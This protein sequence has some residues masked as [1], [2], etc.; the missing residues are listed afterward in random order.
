[1]G[2]KSGLKERKDNPEYYQLYLAILTNIIFF[3]SLCSF[4]ISETF[5]QDRVRPCNWWATLKVLKF[6]LLWI[7]S[8]LNLSQDVFVVAVWFFS[9]YF[10]LVPSSSFDL[11]TMSWP[12]QEEVKQKMCLAQS[13]VEPHPPVPLSQLDRDYIGPHDPYRLLG[14]EGQKKNGQPAS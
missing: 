11:I 10:F 14:E 7:F 8:F 1:M 6:V 13:S 12:T 2:K 5:L 9:S 3:T 4:H